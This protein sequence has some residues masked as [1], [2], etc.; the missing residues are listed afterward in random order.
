M[1]PSVKLKEAEKVSEKEFRAVTEISWV[2]LSRKIEKFLRRSNRGR[3]GRRHSWRKSPEEKWKC[4]RSR[5]TS[6]IRLAW[7]VK[8]DE[9]KEEI[10][11]ER[12][13]ALGTFTTTLI[14]FP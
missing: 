7:R 4:R 2:K 8:G 5:R 12:S 1:T 9:L 13:L 10:E 3:V 11:I 14:F 6:G